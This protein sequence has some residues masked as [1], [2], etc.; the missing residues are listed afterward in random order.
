MA[1][2]VE[3]ALTVQL[4]QTGIHLAADDQRFAYRR[5]QRTLSLQVVVA[6]V[7]THNVDSAVAERV[8]YQQRKMLTLEPVEH[9]QLAVLVAPQ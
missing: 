6:A 5:L 4:D 7:H 8:G 3:V 2:A 1:A 9:K